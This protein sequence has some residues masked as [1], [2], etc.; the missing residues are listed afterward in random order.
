[1]QRLATQ[2]TYLYSYLLVT[3]FGLITL[4]YYNLQI[5]NSGNWCDKM[6]LFFS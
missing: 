1:M 2:A 4:V 3:S 5:T 6:G